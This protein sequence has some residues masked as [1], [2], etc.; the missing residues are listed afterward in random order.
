MA[1]EGNTG[2]RDSRADE[3]RA[4][5]EA[6]SAGVLCTLSERLG[7]W[8]FGSLASYA[9]TSRGEPIFLFSRLAQ[10]TRNLDADS[11]ATLFVYDG[12]GS[13]EDPQTGRRAALA[14]RVE[15]VPDDQLADARSRYVARH[16]QSEPYFDLDFRLYRL[17]VEHV[18]FVGGFAQAAWIPAGDVIREA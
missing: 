9:L 15:L 4:L 14:G 17:A 1:D 3:V 18:H 13:R 5:L 16:P 11:R 8:P 6:H 10:H 7:G 2:A 12:L